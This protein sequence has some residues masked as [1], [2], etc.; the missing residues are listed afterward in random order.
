MTECAPVGSFAPEKHRVRSK[1]FT[2]TSFNRFDQEQRPRAT[3]LS[4]PLQ[5]HAPR[6]VDH[7]G[8]SQ[9]GRGPS[10]G[11]DQAWQRK[12]TRPVS[13][14]LWK[15]CCN[16]F[17]F[18]APINA[19]LL[20]DGFN[21]GCDVTTRVPRHRC[22]N[23]R[24]ARFVRRTLSAKCSSNAPYSTWCAEHWLLNARNMQT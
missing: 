5:T 9:D 7:A 18:F 8:P 12:N 2:Q 11:R 6:V 15:R 1:S 20:T 23:D 4:G 19:V 21:D 13:V 22:Q 16:C 24:S 14:K 17:S 10:D 3:H